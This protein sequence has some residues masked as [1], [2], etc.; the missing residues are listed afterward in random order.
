MPENE[1]IRFFRGNLPIG[2]GTI[3][4]DLTIVEIAYNAGINIPTNCTSGTCGTCLVRLKKGFIDYPEDLPPGLD[5]FLVE[6]G[7]FL[8]CCMMPKGEC[9][10]DIIP[11]L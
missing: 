8:P 1:L 10:I 6:E 3:E 7:G 11:P 2:I 5:D 9:E 4:P